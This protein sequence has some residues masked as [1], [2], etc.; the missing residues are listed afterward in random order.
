[1]TIH[2]NVI[3]QVFDATWTQ[4]PKTFSGDSV[5]NLAEKLNTRK[6]EFESNA[7]YNARLEKLVTPHDYKYV[8][9]CEEIPFKLDYDA[10]AQEF[11]FS[12]KSYN[13]HIEVAKT[14][15]EGKPYTG[16]NSFGVSKKIRK[17][18]VHEYN[19]HD[20]EWQNDAGQAFKFPYPSIQAAALKSDLAVA[21]II[22][23]APHR[24]FGKSYNSMTSPFFTHSTYYSE[25][26]ISNPLDYMS[27][28]YIITSNIRNI[29][30][31]KKSDRKILLITTP[32]KTKQSSTSPIQ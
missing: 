18:E 25:P 2:S 31:Y 4:L 19:L 27:H 11:I 3:A 23:L 16:T 17:I 22:E 32:S 20:Q 12:R 26:T 8:L 30:L 5:K 29:V 21:L 24:H 9:F 15:K 7:D 13:A 1:M 14:S 6:N 28:S 10:D